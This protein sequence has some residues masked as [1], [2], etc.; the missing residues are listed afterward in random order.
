M[1]FLNYSGSP[2]IGANDYVSTSEWLEVAST[3]ASLNHGT[4]AGFEPGLWLSG[5]GV[6]YWHNGIYWIIPGAIVI[7][8][9]DQHMI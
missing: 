1:Q 8:L 6:E 4:Y 3:T 9:V 2:Y 5:N 7:I